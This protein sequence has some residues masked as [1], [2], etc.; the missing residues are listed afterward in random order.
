M[1]VRR[2]GDHSRDNY[3]RF[4]TVPRRISGADNR[5]R[6]RASVVKML[7]RSRAMTDLSRDH[8]DLLLRFLISSVFQRF[9][10]RLRGEDLLSRS[11]AMTAM[12]R[13]HGDLLLRSLPSSVFPRFFFVSPRLR[14][15]FFFS[16]HAR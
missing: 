12:S 3:R 7:F 6:L 13:D 2:L 1:V 5:P 10:P 8:G 15:R 4:L 14:G 16:D 11:R 9:S